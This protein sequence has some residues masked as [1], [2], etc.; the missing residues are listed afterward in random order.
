[1]SGPGRLL[2]SPSLVI[3]A[4]ATGAM[5]AVAALAVVWTP[6]SPTAMAVAERLQGPSARHLLGTDP[7]GRDVA[8]QL[9]VGATTSFAIALAAIGLAMAVGTALGLIAAARPG[10]FLSGLVLRVADFAF[11]FPVV[12]TAM[13]VAAIREPGAANVVA[14]VALFNVPVFVRLVR[15]AALQVT[16][17]D[18]VAAARL[19]GLG[20]AR[21]LIGEV[22]PNVLGPIV[23]QA[24]IQFA[25]AILA[26][27]GLSYLGLGVRPP[28]PS[29]GRMLAEAQT[30]MGRQ[31]GLAIFPGLAIAVSVIGLNLLGDGLRDLLDPKGRRRLPSG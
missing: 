14:A 9:M 28:A 11:A 31:P 27:A 29:W 5:V 26:E 4:T 21:I 24:T 16:A 8:S 15:G 10:S 30:Y 13:L 17:L 25:L 2:R 12:L 1:M 19:A 18:F 20:E 7:F 23:V 3:G 22:L 6:R